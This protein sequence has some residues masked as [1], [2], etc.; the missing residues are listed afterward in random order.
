MPRVPT[1]DSFQAQPSQLP[2][3]TFRSPLSE[4]H[5]VPEPI[6]TPA[7]RFAAAP[8]A[9]DLPDLA[10]RVSAPVGE[11]MT[12][13]AEDAGRIGLAL[14][15]HANTL[16]VNDAQNRALETR[17]T[18]TYDP[19][20]GYLAQKGLNALQRESGK[21]LEDEY[22]ERL[23][24]RYTQLESEL[25]NTAQREA[26]RAWADQDLG[27]FRGEA[28]RHK[29]SEY[30]NYA[31]SVSEGTIATAV[32]EVGLKWDDPA[33]TAAAVERSAAEVV[34][35]GHL[36]GKSAE[37]IV[38]KQREVLS[39]G[40]KSA[41]KQ[42]LAANQPEYADAYLKHHA[43]DMT[44]DDL[45]TLRTQIDDAGALKLATGAVGELGKEYRRRLDPSDADAAFEVLIGAESRGRQFRPDGQPLESP[46]GA[47]GIAQVMPETAPEAARLAGLPWDETRYRT[48]PAYNRA[49]GR[50][51]F[52]KQLQD[53]GGDVAKAY[54]AYNAGPGS[55]AKGTGLAGALRKAEQAGNPDAWR[56]YLPAETQAY[57]A[58][59]L[60]KLEQRRL[61]GDA[62]TATHDEMRQGL[63]DN[64]KVA[65]N[66]KALKYAAD[67]LDDDLK[68]ADDARKQRADEAE[69]AAITWLADNA[70]RWADM[71]AALRAAIPP[72]ALEGVMNFAKKLRKGEDATDP[73]LYLQLSN[74]DTL[75][76]L[77]D[78]EFLKTRAGLS[79]SDW[80]L[81]AREREKLRNPSPTAAHDPGE[82]NSPAIKSGLDE[83]LRTLGMDPT[84]KD[85]TPEAARVGALRQFVD[86]SIL[87]LQRESGKKLNDA[88]V[89][90]HLDRLFAQNVAVKGWFSDSSGPMVKMKAGD[91]PR[92]ERQ[93]IEAAYAK[94]GVSDPT[95]AQVLALYW[96]AKLRSAP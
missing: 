31:L 94:R 93:A 61:R 67:L 90:A 6:K 88:E 18:L 96:K 80:K 14:A 41:V 58:G 83:R 77:S 26:F 59:N 37:W 2:K 71:P 86:K 35:M 25:G 19:E 28:M 46:A 20:Q 29:A 52:G 66:P 21:S 13:A 5:G 84:P 8:P 81:K 92:E 95:D 42:A 36:Q 38:A 27:Q 44:A 65:G 12:Q 79:E 72:K 87:D 45:V 76:G 89:A 55:A 85:G 32:R 73:N 49:L 7:A 3:A 15:E 10:G 70:G 78:E 22:A 68:S 11:V 40:H 53:N 62:P 34:R 63:L 74:P 82:L 60:R 50:A 16:R 54:A 39:E 30:P 51:Y 91:I 56:D 23:K 17:L 24:E 43:A 48:D 69:S 57:V 47:I 4:A 75:K 1:Y 64:P 9:P 33:A